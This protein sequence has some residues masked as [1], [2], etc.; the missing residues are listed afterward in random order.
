M[1]QNEKWQRDSSVQ[2]TF[3]IGTRKKEDVF[4]LGTFEATKWTFGSGK[5]ILYFNIHKPYFLWL[6]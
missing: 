4:D 3:K 2:M 1:N 6:V 5:A